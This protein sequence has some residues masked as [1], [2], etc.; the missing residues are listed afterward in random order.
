MLVPV[1]HI[2]YLGMIL[3]S[4]TQ[5]FSVPEDKREKFA[6]LREGLLMHKSAV[7]LKSIQKLMCKCI[8][9]SLAFPGTKF[10]IRDMPAAIAKASKGVEVHLSSSLREE[11]QFDDFWTTGIPSSPGDRKGTLRWLFPRMPSF[12]VGQPLFTL[13]LWI[14]LLVTTKTM[15]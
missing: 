3:E 8:S 14:S 5:A 2:V 15:K 10:Y 4:L 9:F 6:Q 1:T 7:P 13:S 11:I 12:S